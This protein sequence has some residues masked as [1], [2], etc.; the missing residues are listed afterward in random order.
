MIKRTFQVSRCGL[1]LG[2]ADALLAANLPRSALAP[3]PINMA[4]ICTVPAQRQWVSRI[5]I[6]VDAL[7][8]AGTVDEPIPR[9][10]PTE[11]PPNGWTDFR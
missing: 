5:H 4:G 2:G 9:M 1:L 6:A 10:S 8:A 7:M 11:L 3:E